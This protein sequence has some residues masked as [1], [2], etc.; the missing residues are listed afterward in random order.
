VRE[1]K[2]NV[3]FSESKSLPDKNSI[4]NVCRQLFE[5]SEPDL[6]SL[7]SLAR[8]LEMAYLHENK[9]PILNLL[10]MKETQH[11]VFTANSEGLNIM[12]ILLVPQQIKKEDARTVVPTPAVDNNSYV[13]KHQF[14]YGNLQLKFSRNPVKEFPL[15]GHVSDECEDGLKEKVR[16]DWIAF[17]HSC[18]LPFMNLSQPLGFSLQKDSKSE[19]V[20]VYIYL[21]LLPNINSR[22]LSTDNERLNHGLEKKG[23]L[24]NMTSATISYDDYK[25]DSTPIIIHPFIIQELKDQDVDTSK[26]LDLRSPLTDNAEFARNSGN[27]LFANGKYVAS[28]I[29]KHESISEFICKIFGDNS[30][31]TIFSD[32]PNNDE[33]E[34]MGNFCYGVLLYINFYK[35]INNHYNDFKTFKSYVRL[36]DNLNQCLV[37]QK[38]G[39]MVKLSRHHLKENNVFFISRLMFRFIC[40]NIGLLIPEGN[41][42]NYAACLAFTRCQSELINQY[43]NKPIPAEDCLPEPNLEYI[44]PHISCDY[45]VHKHNDNLLNNFPYDANRNIYI[46]LS[47]RSYNDS[48]SSQVISCRD[49]G[50]RYFTMSID[51]HSGTNACI[52]ECIPYEVREAWPKTFKQD[53]ANFYVAI[54]TVTEVIKQKKRKSTSVSDSQQK[55]TKDTD[56]A[57]FAVAKWASQRKSLFLKDLYQR[58]DIMQHV[59]PEYR[60]WISK[61]HERNANSPDT[62]SN[63]DEDFLNHL[64]TVHEANIT[65]ELFPKMNILRLMS[66]YLAGLLCSAKDNSGELLDCARIMVKT[67]GVK[68]QASGPKNMKKDDIEIFNSL[69]CAWIENKEDHEKF[70]PKGTYKVRIVCN[71]FCE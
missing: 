9:Y 22:R 14:S 13:T 59:R 10:D 24:T 68:N 65:S 66:L 15:K 69:V 20:Y 17:H 28:L 25:I 6:A 53:T 31:E 37:D 16:D 63:F 54:E 33:V 56:W 51:K 50:E 27:D 5:T 43:L 18:N 36:F 45:V 23:I 2:I 39:V 49:F 42:R 47:E 52:H 35:A 62:Q 40:N 44:A 7:Y 32:L 26:H 46:K 61:W 4:E 41:G 58:K 70:P 34:K 67:N 30:L 12:W 3:T 11:N 57:S 64:I 48:H 8:F 29:D 60:G 55:V 71:K 1:T 19:R 21:T 38:P